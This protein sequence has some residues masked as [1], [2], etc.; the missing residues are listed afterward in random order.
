LRGHDRRDAADGAADGEQAGELGRE[1][2]DAAEERHDGEGEDQ[3]DGYEAEREAADAEDVGEDELGGYEDDAELEPE[4]VGGD[5]GMEEAREREG[6]G[7]D[8]AEDDGPEDVLDLR[9]GVVMSVEVE[10]E[11]FEGFAGEADGEE[12]QRSRDEREELAGSRRLASGGGERD[13][14]GGRQLSVLSCQFSVVSS[15]LSVLRK[16]RELPGDVVDDV[17]ADEGGEGEGDDDGGRVYVEG[18]LAVASGGF[19]GELLGGWVVRRRFGLRCTKP[20]RLGAG[21]GRLSWR[22]KGLAFA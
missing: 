10:A 20:T 9:E 15:Q 14:L 5:A 3:L 22:A 16:N 17:E 13:G 4:L 1:T 2:E 6:V 18:Q 12:Q 7:E 8:E 21:R 19:H 11:R